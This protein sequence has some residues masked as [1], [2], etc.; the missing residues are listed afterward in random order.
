MFLTLFLSLLY[1]SSDYQLI[2]QI[3]LQN[4][5]DLEKYINEYLN[6]SNIT[7]LFNIFIFSIIGL[8]IMNLIELIL[9]YDYISLPYS[10]NLSHKIKNLNRDNGNITILDKFDFKP[11]SLLK[12]KIPFRNRISLDRLRY[13]SDEAISQ[14]REFLQ[15]PKDSEILFNQ[16]NKKTIELSINHITKEVQLDV[17]KIIKD[18][19]YLGETFNKQDLYLDI[20]K[21]THIL[22][23][24]ESGSGKSTLINSMLLSILKNLNL[25]EK[26]FLVDFKG[27]ELYRYSKIP[28]V[29][30]IDKVDELVSMLEDLTTLMNQRYENLKEIGELKHQG[31][32]IFVVLE[33]VGSISTFQ[34]TKVKNQIF[35]LLINLLQKARAANIYFL[36]FAQKIEISVLPSAITTNIQGKILLKTDTDYNQQQTIGTKEV[37]SQYTNIDPSNFNRGRGLFKDGITSQV[38]L[39]Q[40]PMFD[41]D[42]YKEFI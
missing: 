15:V 24:G 33:E 2:E 16:T 22:T 41:K 12:G 17:N 11:K 27:V 5:N 40:A 34:D 23:V 32:Y 4:F 21:L 39:F 18:K 6:S 31:D 10:I 38:K 37:I 8:N 36:V 25:C 29:N 42:I 14:I 7:N 30:F 3:N 26:L 20:D 35:N 1:F 13:E 9:F 28:K 19:I